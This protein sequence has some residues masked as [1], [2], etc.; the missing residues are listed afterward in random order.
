MGGLVMGGLLEVLHILKI[1]GSRGQRKG[2][3][4]GSK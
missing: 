3:V 2:V 1:K 4:A